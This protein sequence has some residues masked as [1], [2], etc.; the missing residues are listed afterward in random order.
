MPQYD[1]PIEQLLKRK[2]TLQEPSDFWEFWHRTVDESR[3]R[4]FIPIATPVDQGL[5]LVSTMDVQFAG[6]DGQPVHA[7]L[8]RPALNAEVRGVVVRYIGYGGGRGLPHQ[9]THWSAAGYAEFIVDTRG[10]GAAWG[11]V[12]DTPDSDAGEAT[13]AGFMTRGILSPETYYYR[14]VFTDAALAVDAARLLVGADLPV[15]LSGGSQGGGIALAAAAL[16]SNISA[17]MV[18][19]PFLCDFPRGMMIASDGPYLELTGYLGTHRAS[20]DRVF[21]TLAYFDGALLARYATAPALFSVAL[22]DPVCPPSSVYS[23]INSYGGTTDVCVYPYNG[24][25]GGQF[26]QEAEQLR[27][28]PQALGSIAEP[29]EQRKEEK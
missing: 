22:S 18:D 19:V 27:W 25:E 5:Q 17:V 14:R 26:H 12:G 2:P 29:P 10:Q 15:I 9:T 6:F 20:S 3:R 28:L 24:H 13:S 23:A 21:N 4:A 16:S 7:W 11:W 1:E 8:H